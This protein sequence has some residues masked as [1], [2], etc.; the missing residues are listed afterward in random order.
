MGRFPT[1]NITGESQPDFHDIH[2]EKF[3]VN[4]GT[5]GVMDLIFSTKYEEKNVD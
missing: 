4:F 1:A 3:N 2:H 5:V